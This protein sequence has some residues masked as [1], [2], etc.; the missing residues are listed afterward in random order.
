MLFLWG[1]ICLVLEPGKGQI[2]FI[3]SEFVKTY[4][5]ELCPYLTV[6]KRDRKRFSKD[7]PEWLKSLRVLKIKYLPM[8]TIANSI[9]VKKRKKRK[10][11]IN[12]VLNTSIKGEQKH[13][14]CCLTQNCT[15]ARQIKLSCALSLS[16]GFQPHNYWVHAYKELVMKIFYTQVSTNN[17]EKNLQDFVTSLCSLMAHYT[18]SSS[19]VTFW[20]TMKC[21]RPSLLKLYLGLSFSS[22]VSL[23]HETMALSKETSHSKV[24][25][26]RSLTSMLWMRLVK[27]ICSAKKKIKTG[28]GKWHH[29]WECMT[30]AEW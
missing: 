2:I 17:E 1:C 14:K 5:G 9:S 30:I 28:M 4:S 27:W 11:R 13:K 12:R 24:A 10:Y 18:P 8:G 26:C 25:D 6:I 20:M 19:T 16:P 29:N 21:L 22:Q 23:Y 3:M 15:F 7:V